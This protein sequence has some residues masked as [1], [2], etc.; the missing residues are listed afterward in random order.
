[1]FDFDLGDTTYVEDPEFFGNERRVEVAITEMT[2]NLDDPSK[3]NI[4]VQTFK[5]QFQDLF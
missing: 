3:N 2:E 5:D 4:K 1:M